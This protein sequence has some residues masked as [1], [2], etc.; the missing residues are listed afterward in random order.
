[1][2]NNILPDS[3]KDGKSTPAPKEP[4]PLKTKPE[5][6][7]DWIEDTEYA[8]RALQ[9]WL[10]GLKNWQSQDRVPGEDFDRAY[11]VICDATLAG[12]ARVGIV[13][14]RAAVTGE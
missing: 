2:S 5:V 8:I 9:I 3:A 12:W 13:E 1:M 11:A 14:L 7:Q 4:H 10:T 6:L